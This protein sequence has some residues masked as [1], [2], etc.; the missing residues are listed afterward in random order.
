MN[1]NTLTVDQDWKANLSIG[2]EIWWN[3]P[4][5]ITSGYY[6]VDTILSEDGSISDDTIFCLHNSAGSECEAY[7]HELAPTQP[8]GL[9]PVVDG[10]S[11]DIEICGYAFTAVEAIEVGSKSLE[12]PVRD[13]YLVK[14]LALK[15]GTILPCAWVASTVSY[16]V[17]YLTNA[18]GEPTG[19]GTLPL[20]PEDLEKVAFEQGPGCLI[21]YIV[22]INDAKYAIA[23]LEVAFQD[24]FWGDDARSF[25]PYEKVFA[26]CLAANAYLYRRISEGMLLLPPDEGDPGRVTV[27]V[28]I[29]LDVLADASATEA[30]FAHVFGELTDLPAEV[31]AVA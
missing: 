19:Y 16:N 7:A 29:P 25:D 30:A 1:N 28:A 6:S 12:D 10:D 23:N 24:P 13:A 9:F 14:D 2:D 27:S 5:G 20:Q 8:E 18:C 3:D 11:G 17:T 4:E 21:L 31:P 26:Y 22:E 15:D